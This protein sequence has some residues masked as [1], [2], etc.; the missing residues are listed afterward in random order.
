[1]SVRELIETPAAPLLSC[2]ELDPLAKAVKLMVERRVNAILVIEPV[3]R[4]CGILTDHDVMKALDA[5]GGELGDARARDWMSRK[6][7]TCNADEKLGEAMRMMARNRIRHLVVKDGD[8]AV[9]VIGVRA[10]LAK[11]HAQDE[12]ENRV[13]RDMAGAARG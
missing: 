6:L 7:I 12:M 11:L 2:R 4:L 3:E 1:M 5:G 10:V 13:L 8:K 9:A